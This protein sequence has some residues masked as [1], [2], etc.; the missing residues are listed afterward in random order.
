MMEELN[1]ADG[2]C[3]NGWSHFQKEMIMI[4]AED[5]GSKIYLDSCTT[6]ST[7]VGERHL[8]DVA[9]QPRGLAINCNAGVKRTKRRGNF[10]GLKVWAMEDGIA[11]VLLLGEIV[12]R[13]RVNFDSNGG[14]FVVHTP[15]GEV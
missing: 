3:D 14:F 13:H 8:T 15:G 4:Q 7:F 11:N 9:D 5:A 12:K 2:Y 1:L 6:S 10:G